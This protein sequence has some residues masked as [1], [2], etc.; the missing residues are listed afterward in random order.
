VTDYAD[1]PFQSEISPEFSYGC[2]V[3][4]DTDRVTFQKEGYS[5]E[6]LLA[7]LRSCCRKTSGSICFT[8]T[9][10]ISQ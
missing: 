9:S 7:G 4:L 5:R 1:V 10:A 8:S 2:A 3:F 6:E